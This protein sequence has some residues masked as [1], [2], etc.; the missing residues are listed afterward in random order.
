MKQS[1]V[2]TWVANIYVGSLHT[3]SGAHLP[4][5]F[6][7]D[8]VQAYVNDVG[9]CFTVTRTNFIYKNGNEPGLIVGLIRYPRFPLETSVMEDQCLDLAERLRVAMQQQRVSV[10]LPDYTIMLSGETP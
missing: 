4:L 1:R 5:R 10:V 2:K 7:E 9:Q 6:G 3:E 8:V